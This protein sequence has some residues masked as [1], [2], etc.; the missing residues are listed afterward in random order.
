MPSRYSVSRGAVIALIEL[1][2][3]ATGLRHA[4]FPR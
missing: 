2:L 1:P 3:F 4:N